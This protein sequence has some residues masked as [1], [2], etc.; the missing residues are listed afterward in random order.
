MFEFC[1]KRNR[2]MKS[3][4]GL[5]LL[6]KSLPKL[7]QGLF[8]GHIFQKILSMTIWG[9]NHLKKTPSLFLMAFSMKDFQFFF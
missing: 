6:Q 3:G 5:V 9:T 8:T 1:P 2:I 4:R 7:N